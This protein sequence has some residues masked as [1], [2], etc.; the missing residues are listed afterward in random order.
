MGVGP[1]ILWVCL[2]LVARTNTSI[3]LA[4]ALCDAKCR[5]SCGASRTLRL[6]CIA[7]WYSTRALWRSAACWTLPAQV[8]E[9][10]A[11]T[12]VLGDLAAAA[13]QVGPLR[14]GVSVGGSALCR[15]RRKV[16]RERWADAPGRPEHRLVDEA[17]QVFLREGLR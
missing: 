10:D 9:G 4:Q 5:S 2:F 3:K 12:E 7:S 13:Q 16:R 17:V 1:R 11:D 14:L 15:L 8:T 6:S